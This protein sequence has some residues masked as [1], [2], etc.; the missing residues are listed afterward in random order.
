LAIVVC[1][2]ILTI[3]TRAFATA[4]AALLPMRISGRRFNNRGNLVG[5]IFTL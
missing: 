4:T 1:S 2:T 3:P 5:K